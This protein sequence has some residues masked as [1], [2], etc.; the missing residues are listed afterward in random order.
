MLS[1]SIRGRRE[2]AG[3][4]VAT[5]DGTSD[6]AN[7]GTPN[8]RSVSPLTTCHRLE[9]AFAWEIPRI[10]DKTFTK[11]SGDMIVQTRVK[12]AQCSAWRKIAQRRASS[13]MTRSSETPIERHAQLAKKRATPRIRDD[14]FVCDTDRATRSVGRTLRICASVTIQLFAKHR[15]SNRL[16]LVNFHGAVA[17]IR[18]SARPSERQ[19]SVN[20][21]IY[22]N[23]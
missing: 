1:A 17:A 20:H 11:V 8:G 4:R 5:S 6:L 9:A 15:A 2:K 21:T 23:H 7:V 12:R 14:S 16:S 10:A 3:R 22:A 19:H 13:S 18:S